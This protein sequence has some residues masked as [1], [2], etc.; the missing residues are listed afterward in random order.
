MLSKFT[1]SLF[2]TVLF[3]S[4]NNYYTYNEFQHKPSITDIPLKQVTGKMDLY[5]NNERPV[6]PFYKIK[7]V[8]VMGRPYTSYN[9]MLALLKQK[10]LEE[11]MDGIIYLDSKQET[12]YSDVSETVY[13][14]DTTTSINRQVA[15][16]YQRM[17]G[18]GLKYVS[19]INYLD[20][21]VKKSTVKL[22]GNNIPNDSFSIRFDWHG[23]VW[24]DYV[25]TSFQKYYQ[26]V[27]PYDIVKAYETW[28]KGWSIS[29]EPGT[30]KLL[31]KRFQLNTYDIIH[32]QYYY[33]TDGLIDY[34]K[35]KTDMPSVTTNMGNVYLNFD[36]R[37]LLNEK[38][39]VLKKSVIWREKFVYD[40][41]DRCAK[42]IRT[43]GNS[44]KVLLTIEN[45][46]FSNSD[47]PVA[48]K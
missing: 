38:K 10:A 11:G 31:S 25:S 15:N 5:F 16:P 9:E 29:T 13:L 39:L 21:I 30:G 12:G 41:K 33:A 20:T 27:L 44:D 40:E 6:Q 36:R 47:L 8:E 2:V 26:Q 1:S 7:I 19:T 32:Y 34:V 43:A 28:G 23:N 37:G 46:F 3:I 22:Y 35:V 18:I 4:C 42:I 45:E 14:K 48:E 17:T 24:N